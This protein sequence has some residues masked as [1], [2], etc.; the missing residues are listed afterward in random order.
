L[1]WENTVGFLRHYHDRVRESTSNA[2]TFFYH[3]WVSIIDKSNP[4]PWITHEKNALTAW[5]CTASKT[6][7][8]LAADGRADRIQSLPAGGALA[9]LVERVL[10]NEVPR[11]TGTTL[12]RMNTLFTDNVHLTNLGMY[13]MALVVYSA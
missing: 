5:E 4:T 11:I 7:L 8:S 9:D 3:S 2:R 1:D 13:Y 6:N 12:Q 10:N